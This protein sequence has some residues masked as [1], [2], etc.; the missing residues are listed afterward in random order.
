M[1]EKWLILKFKFKL[2]LLIL[3]T[4]EVIIF[5]VITNKIR[6]YIIDF[7]MAFV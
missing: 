7:L 6:N 2:A 4:Q 3:Q 1:K 5:D